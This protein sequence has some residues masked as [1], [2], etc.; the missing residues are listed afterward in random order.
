MESTPSRS[1]RASSG[2]LSPP[3]P[4][5]PRLSAVLPP[6]NQARFANKSARAAGLESGSDSSELTDEDEVA[7]RAKKNK[8]RGRGRRARRTLGT[9][10]PQ[11]QSTRRPHSR[12]TS[13]STVNGA[14]NGGSSGSGGTS[15]SGSQTQSNSRS[16]RRSGVIVPPT[17]WEWAYKKNN[18]SAV[19]G[20]GLEIAP[21]D[22]SP[23]RSQ[24]SGPE[25]TKPLDAQLSDG[26]IDETPATAISEPAPRR[27]DKPASAAERPGLTTSNR[28]ATDDIDT[29]VS[30]ANTNATTPR[31]SPRPIQPDS[32]KVTSPPPGDQPSASE[33]DPDESKSD[34][35]MPADGPDPDQYHGPKIARKVVVA[36]APEP[37]P[38]PE[39]DA[40]PE[41]DPA[42]GDDSKASI[43]PEPED[44]AE[45]EPE[46]EPEPE[47]EI[48]VDPEM[49]PPHRAEALDVLAGMEV[50]F[51][52][53]RERLYADKM[54]EAAK[55]EA[56]I[57]DGTHPE[58]VFFQR[59]LDDRRA[60]RKQLAE[61]RRTLEINWCGTI[62]RAE[63]A[64]AWS[65]WRQA[66]DDLRDGMRTDYARKRRR[67][68][69]EKRAAERPVNIRPV[70]PAPH[71]LPPAPSL[72]S[73]LKLHANPQRAPASV[74]ATPTLTPL[75]YAEAVS[76]LELMAPRRTY[77]HT[78][79]GMGNMPPSGPFT[80]QP[81][82]ASEEEPYAR[83][84]GV[85]AYR[86]PAQ[87]AQYP[88]ALV[89]SYV[90]A[91]A[92]AWDGST[93]RRREREREREYRE[94]IFDSP[95][96]G[97]AD[98]ED[99]RPMSSSTTGWTATGERELDP[100]DRE[101]TREWQRKMRELP[102]EPEPERE[103]D[104]LRERERERDRDRERDRPLS[105]PFTIQPFVGMSDVEMGA[106][107]SRPLSRNVER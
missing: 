81:A 20:L 71:S 1:I 63:E 12:G 54:E 85:Y 28:P 32:R 53:L 41:D 8:G 26:E 72:K 2:S 5:P 27:L 78:T 90:V 38:E 58:L 79:N 83:S 107:G 21:R 70:P 64:A 86:A 39:A 73:L 69:R 100:W 45:P 3:T 68:E 59:Q 51:A 74:R 105:T 62:R 7:Q 104:T 29:P 61:T 42:P 89:H 99:K 44:E 88:P 4:S 92:P 40:E 101:Q 60:R 30:G 77:F 49:Q 52:E 67:L 96:L 106:T 13:E 47:A 36:E 10:A 14:Q 75:S 25:P 84:K 24:S 55:E 37:E 80:Y 103:R 46:P 82:H 97:G 87:G 9:T 102:R 50:R 56:M 23:S 16:S 95:V 65:E 11:E 31:P 91:P 66:R 19:N 33:Q 57:L 18:K 94:P 43:E 17:M 15:V 48:E 93:G 34:V 6:Q 98:K 35:E 76:D 22:G